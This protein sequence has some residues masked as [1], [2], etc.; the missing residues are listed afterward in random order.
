MLI[1]PDLFE[2]LDEFGARP[3]SGRAMFGGRCLG[4]VGLDN[5]LAALRAMP[6]LPIRGWVTDGFGRDVIY[7]NPT[8]KVA[9]EVVDSYYED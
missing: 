4:I 6:N 7:Y 5:L 8:V 2:R 1:T 3:Y 9:Q